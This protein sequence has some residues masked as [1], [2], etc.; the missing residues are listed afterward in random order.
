MKGVPADNNLLQEEDLRKDLD[1]F[2]PVSEGDVSKY[3]GAGVYRGKSDAAQIP[4]SEIPSYDAT[5]GDDILQRRLKELEQ[6][7]LEGGTAEENTGDLSIETND[8]ID[9]MDIIR[10]DTTVLSTLGLLSN[11]TNISTNANE[12]ES[13]DPED[14]LGIYKEA[15]R[16]EITSHI[17]RERARD[18]LLKGLREQGLMDSEDADAE[19]LP[20]GMNVTR[21]EEREDRDYDREY[22]MKDYHRDEFQ[23]NYD[24]IQPELQELNLTAV[25]G[26]EPMGGYTDEKGMKEYINR[27]LDLR[28]NESLR[29]KEEARKV[30]IEKYNITDRKAQEEQLE[31][32][33]HMLPDASKYD[34]GEESEEDEIADYVKFKED[35]RWVHTSTDEEIQKTEKIDWTNYTCT[36]CGTKEDVIRK[37]Y[38]QICRKCFRE[39][40]EGV[41]FDA[42]YDPLVYCGIPLEGQPDVYPEPVKREWNFKT[43]CKY[44]EMDRKAEKEAK[45]EFYEEPAWNID[46]MD[47]PDW[48]QQYHD[49]ADESIMGIDAI[50][51]SDMP[52]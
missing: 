9:I 18:Y 1:D 15:K 7:N 8:D 51:D 10:N 27:Q 20:K 40:A 21:A 43:A 23:P 38:L 35:R 41:Q 17:F 37:W 49:S 13:I 30:L 22:P 52:F 25:G 45:G 5:Q 11:K 16:P 2:E 46:E 29:Q 28:Y 19:E 44:A 4:L 32:M 47:R 50:R 36:Q 42:G 34:P 14:P 31:E 26:E 39:N 33:G 24:Q 3:Q 6:F 12:E 48:Y